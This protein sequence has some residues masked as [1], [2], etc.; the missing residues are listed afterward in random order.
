MRLIWD[1]VKCISNVEKHGLDFLDAVWVLDSP[2]RL[3]I[4]SERNHE[5]RVQSFAYVFEVLAV[6]TL[7]HVPDQ[8]GFRI[9]SFRRA[10]SDEEVAYHGWLE[11]DF[12][13]DEGRA[14]S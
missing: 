14:A 11:N 9:I 4:G 2:I 7:V 6:L 5:S 3:D 12:N 10:S 13:D 8:E 1:E